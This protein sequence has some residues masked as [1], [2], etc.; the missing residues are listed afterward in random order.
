MFS[1]TMVEKTKFRYNCD[2]TPSPEGTIVDEVAMEEKLNEMVEGMNLEF[3][4]TI[5]LVRL[6]LCETIFRREG[7]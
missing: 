7:S 2:D 5:N 1:V 4:L 3:I 6:I